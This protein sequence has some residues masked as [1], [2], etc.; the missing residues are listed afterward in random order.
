[1]PAP[2]N[3]AAV[4]TWRHPDQTF[5]FM[6]RDKTN[7]LFNEIIYDIVDIFHL[8]NIILPQLIVKRAVTS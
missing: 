2:D 4:A 8:L 6:D 5:L 3:H 7:N 1:M